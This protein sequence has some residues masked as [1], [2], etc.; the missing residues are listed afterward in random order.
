MLN[1]HDSLPKRPIEVRNLRS[2]RLRLRK[3]R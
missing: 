3:L 1:L 2:R